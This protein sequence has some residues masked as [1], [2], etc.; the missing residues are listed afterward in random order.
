MGRNN[1]YVSVGVHLF[2]AFEGAERG[3]GLDGQQR[4]ERQQRAFLSSRCKEGRTT[5]R[6]R[7]T[8]EYNKIKHAGEMNRYFC[9]E[10]TK[11]GWEGVNEE[12]KGK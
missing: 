10:T 12:K 11:G 1:Q 8:N 4:C 7:L 3:G 6:T 5:E 9:S 2:V